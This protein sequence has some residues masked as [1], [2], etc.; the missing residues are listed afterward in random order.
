MPNYMRKNLEKWLEDDIES[1]CGKYY[2]WAY[3]DCISL[4]GNIPF[5]PATHKWYANQPEDIC[6]QDCPEEDGGSC[7]GLAR[8]WDTLY[9]NLTACC[10]EE[11]FWIVSPAC[12][13]RLT[14]S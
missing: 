9:E 6:Q 7:G 13:A 1:C 11:I 5:A 10:V 14:I 8:P 4:S 12:E 2:K 3:S